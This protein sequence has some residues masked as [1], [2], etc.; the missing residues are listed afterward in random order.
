M[1]AGNASL[2]ANFVPLPALQVARS[3]GQ[4]VLSWSTNSAAFVLESSQALG[5]TATW[6]PVSAPVVVAGGSCTVTLG[7]SGPARYFRLRGP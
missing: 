3:G 4:M 7:V 2:V 5:G 1:V 6:N